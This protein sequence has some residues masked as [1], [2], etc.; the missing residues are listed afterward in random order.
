MGRKA[1][2]DRREGKAARGRA[3]VVLLT[4]AA[5]LPMTR[6]AAQ[7]MP[8]KQIVETMAQREADAAAHREKYM[9]LSNE[10]SERTGGHLWME[11]V[12]ETPAGRVRLLLQEDGRRLSPE[13]AEAEHKRLAAEAAHPESFAAKEKA[14]KDEEAH[15]R[16]M[17]EL[18]GK[19][20]LLE[21]LRAYNQDW[22]IEFQP[23]P[24]YSPNGIEERVLHGMSG[25]MLIDQ[26]SLRLHHIEGRLPQNVS[27]GF[28]LVATVKAGS[29]FESTKALI[30]GQWRTVK[31][32][33]DFRGKAAVFKTIATNADVSRSE[34]V[35]V[36]NN[37]TVAQAVEK[38]EAAPGR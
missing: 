29:H 27:I 11:R 8:A 37:L 7:T 28:G 18:L 15:A 12:V 31:V 25:W 4:A 32:V 36:D 3:G 19:G 33:S 6:I 38:V 9:Y 20:F 22:R 5:V 2:A 23:D 24:S 26:K 17:L 35:R 34:F 13:R 14:Q 21:N 16:Q 10:R 1:D 30:E